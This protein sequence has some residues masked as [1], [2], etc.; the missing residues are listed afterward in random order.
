MHEVLLSGK[1]PWGF[2]ISGG[3][4]MMMP[5]F[6]SKLAPN[7]KA[8]NNGV[9][10]GDI[11]VAVN[12]EYVENLSP[13]FLMEKLQENN[14]HLHLVL[15]STTEPEGYVHSHYTESS[16]Y[17]YK[18][19]EAKSFL[20]SEKREMSKSVNNNY[21]KEPPKP[22]ARKRV[23]LKRDQSD[24]YNEESSNEK[25]E[26][27]KSADDTEH[28]D[29][30]ND[31]DEDCLEPQVHWLQGK[32]R[33]M[34]LVKDDE[35]NGE[36]LKSTVLSQNKSGEQIQLPGIK[37]RHKQ[38]NTPAA[39]YSDV[40]MHN[41]L[42]EQCSSDGRRRKNAEMLKSVPIQVDRNSSVYKLVHNIDSE[43]ENPIQSPSVNLLEKL[44]ERQ[45]SNTSGVDEKRHITTRYI[46]Q[47]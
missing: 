14:E 40:V 32:L 46:H 18:M 12:G 33:L 36:N 47:D 25:I 44:Y 5:I 35:N 26:T 19:F 20:I 37:L 23:K 43:D 22:K 13:D 1:P 9:S 42:V 3:N 34:K 15:E 30:E 6:I 24:C 27:E 2:R 21:K 41:T 17:K 45:Y 31:F 29:E 8:H 11:L 28:I 39:L 4:A 7:G 10:L 16:A 38:Y